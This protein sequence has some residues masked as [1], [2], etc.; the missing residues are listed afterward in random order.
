MGLLTLTVL[1]GSADAPPV[2]ASG[3][4][5]DLIHSLN[6]LCPN[7]KSA[8]IHTAGNIQPLL[9]CKRQATCQ[10]SFSSKQTRTSDKNYPNQD[11]SKTVHLSHQL[12]LLSSH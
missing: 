5:R 8:V 4:W 6:L 2:L 1:G 11:L 3:N 12:H 7:R 10:R 9:K